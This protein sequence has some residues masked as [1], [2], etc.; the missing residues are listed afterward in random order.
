MIPPWFN[1]RT[2]IS[3]L[4]R[5]FCTLSRRTREAEGHVELD[6]M[7]ERII[8]EFVEQCY[9][10][11]H[12][13]LLVILT[14]GTP[15]FG[16]IQ[17]Q[18]WQVGKGLIPASE[19]CFHKRGYLEFHHY[20][21]HLT[22]HYVF[23][24]LGQISGICAFPYEQKKVESFFRHWGRAYFRGSVREHLFH[25]LVAKARAHRFPFEKCV[26]MTRT[27]PISEPL[28]WRTIEFSGDA[29]LYSDWMYFRLISGGLN[30]IGG[31]VLGVSVSAGWTQSLWS[32]FKDKV[33]AHERK[34]EDVCSEQEVVVTGFV[35]FLQRVVNTQSL[36]KTAEGLDMEGAR[37]NAGVICDSRVQSVVELKRRPWVL[38]YFR[39]DGFMFP[40]KLW[41]KIAQP[42]R[43]FAEV[44]P[45]S[46]NTQMGQKPCFLKA[47][48]AAF[49][50]FD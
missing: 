15:L 27:V 20:D 49:L 23:V 8:R 5:V 16:T 29:P 32:S 2:L 46:V 9:I 40:A 39:T 25:D 33:R 48:A 13:T 36:K 11:G 35:S 18:T 30:S 7:P 42:V 21:G 34:L 28:D 1:H 31:G 10:S 37:W 24:P 26:S 19:L 44:V 17:V 41:E 50:M 14:D 45:A 43:I 3:T 4:S 47:R 12:Y 6:P 38:A 22:D